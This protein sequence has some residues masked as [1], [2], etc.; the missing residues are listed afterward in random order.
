MTHYLL[1]TLK[2]PYS[3][4]KESLEEQ[5]RNLSREKETIAEIVAEIKRRNE[6]RQ[7]WLSTS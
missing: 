4:S 5:S 6:E 2:F 7:A 3:Y 1:E